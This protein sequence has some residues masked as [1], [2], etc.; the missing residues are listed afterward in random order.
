MID[1]SKIC[2]NLTFMETEVKPPTMREAFNKMWEDGNYNLWQLPEEERRQFYAVFSE[3]IETRVQGEFMK[4]Y[5][6]LYIL[7]QRVYEAAALL[8]ASPSPT[9]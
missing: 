3:V 9:P 7:Q 4:S 6:M 5:H 8:A 2:Y 1:N